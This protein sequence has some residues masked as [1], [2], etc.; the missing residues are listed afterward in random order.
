MT[1]AQMRDAISR[2]YSNRT[3]RL[4]V[5]QM[6]EKQILAVYNSFLKYDKFSHKESI[7]EKKPVSESYIIQFD[8][9][10]EGRAVL[11]VTRSTEKQ[12]EIVRT[13][14]NEEAIALYDR[15]LKGDVC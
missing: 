4:K 11:I 14:F 8:I 7:V 2:V 15:I 5:R 1:D 13:A 10:S 12:L 3:W 9:D 6:P